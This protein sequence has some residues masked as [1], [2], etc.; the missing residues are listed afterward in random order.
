MPL[1]ALVARMR[2]DDCGGRLGRMEPADRHR[3][4]SSSP[5][6]ASCCGRGDGAGGRGSPADSS[7]CRVAATSGAAAS[8]GADP[9]W[10]KGRRPQ[11]PVRAAAKVGD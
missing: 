3:C 2:H 9:S 4:V 6:R 5:A 1:G 8:V 10:E 7:A 11:Q